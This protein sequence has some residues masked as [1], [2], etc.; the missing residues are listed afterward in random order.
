MLIQFRVENHRSLKDE[1]TLSMVAANVGDPNDPRLMRPAGLGEALLPVIALYGANASGKSN[2]LHAL[3]LMRAAVLFSHRQWKPEGG[4][5]QEPFLLSGG[6][7]KP[8]LFETD[9]II[10][11]V[12]HRYGFV[13]GAERI[14]EEWLFAW[15]NGRKQAWFE[16]QG[17]DFDFGKNLR[18]ENETIRALTRPNSLFLSTAAQNNHAG[19]SPVFGWFASAR[20]AVRGA[21][22]G[23]LPLGELGDMFDPQLSFFSEPNDGR[24]AILRMLKAGD[25]GVVDV[26]AIGP[27][28]DGSKRSSFFVDRQGRLESPLRFKHQTEDGTDAWLPLEAESTGTVT[29][30]DIAVRLVRVLRTGGLLCIDELERSLHP[31]FALE[32]VRLFNDPKHNAKGAQL[33]FTTHDTNLLGNVLGEPPLRRDQIWFTEKD[34]AGATKLYPLT[35]FHPRKEENIERGYLQGRYGAIPFLGELVP[36]ADPPEEK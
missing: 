15:P 33:I 34:K 28:V 4:T 26:R 29:L 27:R 9:V 3:N 32:I 23:F 25:I 16:R 13:L 11:G 10:D 22:E 5:P 21:S 36:P 19:L 35:E 6:E 20:F 8:S 31:M 24:D 2:V 30:L 14:E 1:Q 18:G 7:R 12:R 17:D